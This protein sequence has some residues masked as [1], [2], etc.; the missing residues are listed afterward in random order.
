M[1][2]FVS[3]GF[4]SATWT[5]LAIAMDEEIR[6]FFFFFGVDMAGIEFCLQNLI[7]KGRVLSEFNF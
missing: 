5:V 2:E 6:F 4:S 1:I 7:V 3:C